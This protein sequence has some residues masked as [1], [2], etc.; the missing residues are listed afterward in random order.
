[1]KNG[2][3]HDRVLALKSLVLASLLLLVN[4]AAAAPLNASGW[5]P[6]HVGTTPRAATRTIYFVDGQ[7]GSDSNPGTASQPWQTIEKATTSIQPGSNVII[8]AGIY[9][10]PDLILVFEPAGLDANRMTIFKAQKGARVI[11]TGPNDEPIQVK[12]NDYVRVQGLWFGG[13][14][15]TPTRRIIS[16]GGQPIGHSQQMVHNTIFGYNTGILIGAGEKT[17]IQDNRFVNNSTDKKSAAIYVSSGLAANGALTQHVIIDHNIVIGGAGYGVQGWHTPR[18]IIYSRN[19]IA[20]HFWGS[21]FNG[22]DSLFANNFYWGELG[23]ST[24]PPF[25]P[26]IG[27]YPNTFMNNVFGPHGWVNVGNVNVT[28]P[29]LIFKNNAFTDEHWPQG[30]GG[31]TCKVLCGTGGVRLVQGQELQQLGIDAD[32]LNNAIADLQRSFAR[33]IS[34]IYSDST[35]EPNFSTIDQMQVPSGSPLYQTGFPWTGLPINVGTDAPAPANFWASFAN[36]GFAQWDRFGH[37][38]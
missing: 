30:I 25:G 32:R 13:T 8:A 2:S 37:P 4:V 21:A 26:L 28:F 22:K 38:Q 10:I 6:H 12:V 19:F 34:A 20:S 31:N 3:I 17:L 5:Q 9:R 35:I 7:L 29:H 11:V 16:V 18:N 36:L 14:S 1:M 15:T 27:T 23:T 33:S 24:L